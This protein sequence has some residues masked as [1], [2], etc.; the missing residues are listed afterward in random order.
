M[1][2]SE[3]YGFCPNCKASWEDKRPEE[4]GYVSLGDAGGV[5]ICTACLSN[6][7]RL[8]LWKIRRNLKRF[9]GWTEK[10][11]DEAMTAI[12]SAKRR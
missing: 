9:A 3:E 2:Q 5:S 4:V 8:I 1:S 7:W 6:Q 10:D 11:V 12:A